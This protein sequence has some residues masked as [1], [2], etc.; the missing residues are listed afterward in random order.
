MDDPL[1]KRIAALEEQLAALKKVVADLRGQRTDKTNQ[2]QDSE[3]PET[4][5]SFVSP[6]KPVY[7]NKL[8][9]DKKDPAKNSE[10][11][12]GRLGIALLLFGAAFLF[13]Y[14]IE[15][16]WI[17]PLVRVLFGF[18]LGIILLFAGLR[19]YQKKRTLS[20]MLL[21]GGIATYYITIFSAFQ[22]YYLLSYSAA[23]T[24]MVT[25]TVI[26]FFLA[27]K[28][29][30]HTL[31]LIGAL[32]GFLTPFLLYTGQSN[33]FGLV[34]YTSLL[35][36][37]SSLTYMVRGWRILLWFSSWASWIIWAV[38]IENTPALDY[39]SNKWIIQ[40]AI[41]L[42]WAAFTLLPAFRE[43]EHIKNPQKWPSPA[44]EFAYKRL[45]KM[46]GDTLSGHV[47]LLI[48]VTPLLALL[49]TQYNW[50][51]YYE[52]AGYI[53]LCVSIIYL[54]TF[55]FLRVKEEFKDLNFSIGLTGIIIFTWSILLIFKETSQ[56]IIISL[57]SWA[58]FIIAQRINDNRLEKTAKILL[59]LMC[60]FLLGRIY[61][62]APDMP[63]IFNIKSFADIL[64][65]A[66]L[67][68]VLIR[69]KSADVQILYLVAD[70][71]GFMGWLLRE[72]K[73][74]DNGQG[75]ITIAWGITGITIFILGLRQGKTPVRHLG[76][77]TIAIVVGKLFLVDLSELETIW[78]ILLFLG[79]GGI[80]LFVSYFLEKLIK[81]S[82]NSK[83]D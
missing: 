57:E 42:S 30:E 1:E 46:A 25:V 43:Y 76:A 28:Q 52:N 26:A 64:F 13:K 73:Y 68:H 63:Y 70:L 15:Q 44:L 62:N 61:L 58:L 34:S 19:L 65:I 9:T 3:N 48:L 8:A 17:T 80:L 67:T 51:I 83:S 59:A 23:F 29:D 41:I 16:G 20:R 38:A 24:L 45:S 12:I 60:I 77:V 55:I 21:G 39:A 56:F 75:L 78:R 14:S 72:L 11:W 18:F 10:I 50:D 33:I 35:V 74:F 66:L 22:L 36:I 47:H 71:A 82:K 7:K 40:A 79:F 37:G 32:G 53:Y 81:P 2:I 31:S 27:L 4:S 54:L 69:M 49:E 6:P 5:Q